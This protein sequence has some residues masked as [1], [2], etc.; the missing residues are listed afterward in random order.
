[1]RAIFF[2]TPTVA[3]VALELLLLSPDHGV[4]AV[5]TQPD[6]A[7]GRSGKLTPSPVK[8]RALAEHLPILQPAS[9]KHEGFTEQLAAYEPDVLA[10]VAYG[11][12]LPHEVLAVAPAVN[13]HFSL[14]PKYRGAAPVQRAIQAGE[15]ATGVTTFLLEPSVDSGPMLLQ[16]RVAIGEEET[17]GELLERLA[18]IGARLL[19]ASLDALTRGS[20]GG[21]PQ[22]PSGATPAPKIKPEEARIDWR[23]PAQHIANTIRAFNPAPGAFTTWSE[24]RLKIWRARVT[25]EGSGAPG[26]VTASDVPIVACGGQ[27]LALL[28]VQAEGSRTMSGEEFLR[29]HKAFATALLES[30]EQA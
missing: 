14:L 28:E 18:P 27:S 20:T 29:G 22:D 4:A 25:P 6:R 5:V 3:A 7:R 10:V 21:E 1:M 15:K 26:S 13:A 11:H 8:E 2:G 12:I 17:A 30:G 16:E 9:P 23:R 24:G 19:V